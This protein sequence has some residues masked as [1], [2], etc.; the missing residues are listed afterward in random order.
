MKKIVLLILMAFSLSNIKT[1]IVLAQ[2]LYETNCS[3]DG[4]LFLGG[5][6]LLVLGSYMQGKVTPLTEDEINKLSKDDVNAFDRSSTSKWSPS[7]RETSNYILASCII[8][9]TTLLLSKAI[10]EDI[11][12]LSVLYLETL[13]LTNGPI[14]LSKGLAKRIR[15]YVYN[16]DVS[17]IKK[18]KP[19]ARKS[20]YSG[21]TANAFAPAILFAKIYSDYYPD[22]KWK[23]AIWGTALLGASAVAYLTY[24]AG[25]HFPTDIL[26]GAV[27]GSLT[28]YLVS[29]FHKKNCNAGYS[30]ASVFYGRQVLFKINF[31]L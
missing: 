14:L 22:S 16:P 11:A 6:G 27:M 3:K 19:D 31:N 7:A 17:M 29:N 13:L 12:T 18:T 1:S 2:V 26:T 4:G 30:N 20:F 25:M 24:E 15:P 23:P 21:H 10:R 5:T 8:L 28:G 9:P